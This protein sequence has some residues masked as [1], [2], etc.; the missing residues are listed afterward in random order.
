MW[1]PSKELWKSLVVKANKGSG[2]ARDYIDYDDLKTNNKWKTEEGIEFGNNKEYNKSKGYSKHVLEDILLKR[3]L[4]VADKIISENTNINLYINKYE[5]EINN[6]NKS[7]F[8]GTLATQTLLE[9]SK[10]LSGLDS[11]L[12]SQIA[13]SK[14]QDI[15]TDLNMEETFGIIL[16][17]DRLFASP[18]NLFTTII[19]YAKI[20]K[21]YDNIVAA[22]NNKEPKK[23]AYPP[24][25]KGETQ[26][27]VTGSPI[28][29]IRLQNEGE[30]DEAYQRFLYP[31]K[32]KLVTKISSEKLETL[33]NTVA[34][35][36]RGIK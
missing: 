1:I 13:S 21:K 5:R 25:Y 33:G 34:R 32:I 20:N 17:D 8:Y 12:K 15:I 27:D 6:S 23:S 3:F 22:L 7:Y 35:N 24:V 19:E 36:C 2:A 4:Y 14:L 9:T 11:D 26:Q 30:S 18:S 31:F 29:T 10:T 28:M 16:N